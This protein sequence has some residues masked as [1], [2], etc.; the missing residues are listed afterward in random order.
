M[1]VRWFSAAHVVGI[2]RIVDP[3]EGVKYYIGAGRGFDEAD[4]VAYIA[5]WGSSFPN[6]IGDILFD[7]DPLRDG[8][9]V[10]VPVSKE[11]AEAMVNVGMFYLEGKK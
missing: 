7:G 3:Y 1:N 8:R 6:Q 5:G 4:D 9:A 11:H 10:P 2:V